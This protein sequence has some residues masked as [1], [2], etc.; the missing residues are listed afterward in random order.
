MAGLDPFDIV[1]RRFADELARQERRLVDNVLALP[2]ALAHQAVGSTLQPMID[3]MALL[4]SMSHGAVNLILEQSRGPF[5]RN[6]T[7][8]EEGL[9][10][11]SYGIKVLPSEVRII[12]GYGNSRIAF[13]AFLNGN[14]AITLGNN[15][16]VQTGLKQINLSDLSMT[17][18]GIDLLIHEYTHVIQYAV[19]GFSGFSARYLRELRQFGGNANEL[20]RYWKRDVP[21]ERETLEAQAQMQGNLASASHTPT[22]AGQVSARKLHGRIYGGQ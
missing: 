8:G 10:R 15:I 9:V 14:P 17:L 18:T 13:A 16:F 1:R 19:L 22:A 3:G 4:G 11:E 6:L 2:G 20:Y 5:A 12:P 21:Y 7:P